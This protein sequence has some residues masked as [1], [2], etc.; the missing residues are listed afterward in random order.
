MTYTDMTSKNQFKTISHKNL[1]A[2]L[3]DLGLTEN[4]SKVYLYLLESGANMTGS[5]IALVNNL[6]RQYVYNSLAKLERMGLIEIIPDGKKLRSRALPPVQVTKMAQRKLNEAEDIEKELKTISTV[7]AEQDFEVYM[8][9]K[10]VR[11]FETRLVNNLPQNTEQYIIGGSSDIFLNFFGDQYYDLAQ[12][13]NKKGL[14]TYYLGG[15]EEMP[16]PQICKDAH[17]NFD[18]AILDSLPRTV[19]NTVIRFDTVT[20]YSLIVPPLVYIIK[21]KRVADDYK[22]FFD[23]LWNMAKKETIVNK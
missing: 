10:Q 13:T 2:K 9:E 5:K 18:Y 1:T 11:E 3:E 20:M 21:S 8:G 23:M 17:N 7:G 15:P 4:D 16:A 22:K 12:I 19:V 6:H 14:K